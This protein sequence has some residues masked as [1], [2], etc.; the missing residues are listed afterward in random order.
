[1]NICIL[2][3]NKSNE[4][5]TPLIPADIKLLKKKT[6]FALINGPISKKH[7]LKKNYQ[8]F[9]KYLA[10]KII[11]NSKLTMLIYNHSFSV[12]PQTTHFP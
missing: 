7:F 4:F 6:A 3:E 11:P 1:M 12:S 5:R 2:K 10:K 9:I 8:G